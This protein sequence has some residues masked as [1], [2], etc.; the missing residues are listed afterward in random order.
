MLERA[1]NMSLVMESCSA[2]FKANVTT[3]SCFDFLF[4]EYLHYWTNLTS[5]SQK[6]EEIAFWSLSSSFISYQIKQALPKLSSKNA[7]AGNIP[8]HITPR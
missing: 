7:L 8:I 4:E 1:L 6:E 3:L 5:V 2:F